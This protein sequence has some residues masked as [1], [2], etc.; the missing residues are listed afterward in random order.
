MKVSVVRNVLEANERIANQNREI[1]DL[2]R[3][4]V[5][6]LMS[7]PG[8]GKTS[9]LEKTIDALKEDLKLGVIEGDVQSTRD[10]DRIARKGIPVIQINTGGACHLDANMVRDALGR[11]E[12]KGLDCLIIENVGN[13]VCPA[14]FKVGEDHKV[15]ILSVTE[16]DDKPEKYPLMFRES[17]VLLINKI[18]LLPY[19]TCSVESIM[20]AARKIR[21]DLE[22]LEISCKTEEGLISW[23]EW[24]RRE[25]RAKKE[26]ESPWGG[27]DD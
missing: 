11:M 16:G 2:N 13:L 19:V 6:N 8:A 14:E 1:F 22:V 15:M 24:I 17:R 7:S 20:E 10:A 26:G 21:P 25:I 5:I 3:V 23:F 18:D 9:L 27:G 4:L 12:I